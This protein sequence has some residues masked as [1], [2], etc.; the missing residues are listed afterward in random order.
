VGISETGVGISENGAGSVVN[1]LSTAK[2]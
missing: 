2:T 1:L